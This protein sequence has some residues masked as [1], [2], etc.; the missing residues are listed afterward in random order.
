MLGN[1]TFNVNAVEVDFSM[2]CIIFNFAILSIKT[3]KYKHN[4]SLPSYPLNSNKYIYI[5]D[6]ET[7]QIFTT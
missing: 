3:E 4:D 2:G 6:G 5:P 7:Q 1:I